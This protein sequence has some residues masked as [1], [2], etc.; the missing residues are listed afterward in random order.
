MPKIELINA[1]Y[2]TEETNSDNEGKVLE[3]IQQNLN[4]SGKVVVPEDMNGFFGF[5]PAPEQA[6]VTAIHVRMLDQ[7]HHLRA[8]EWSNFEWPEIEIVNAWYGDDSYQAA[9]KTAWGLG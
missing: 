4:N 2:G 8:P 1:W 9:Y 3:A 7:E 6:K 5:D